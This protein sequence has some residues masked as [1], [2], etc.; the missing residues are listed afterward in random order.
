MAL[1]LW[2]G[3]A[4]GLLEV[5]L[6]AIRKFG[7]GRIL[8]MGL[9]AAWMNPVGNVVFFLVFGAG[10]TLAAR[11]LPRIFTLRTCIALLVFVSCFGLLFMFA[12]QL[13]KY[14]AMVLAAGLAVELSRR[15]SLGSARFD[16][17][18]RRTMRGMVVAVAALALGVRTTRVL[19][20]RR[21]LARL[22]RSE[23][24][25]NVLLIVLDTVRSLN[26]GY[27]GY[28]RPTTPSLDRWSRGGVRF[29]RALSAAP[30]TL[31]SHASMFTGRFPHQLSADWLEPLDPTYPTIAEF[32]RS[33]GYQTAGFVA[34]VGYCSPEFGLNRGFT[35]YED[36]RASPGQMV[37]QMSL[38]AYLTDSRRLRR[39]VGYYDLLGRKKAER[40]TSNFLHW[41]PDDPS[42]PFFAF[43]NYFDAHSPYIP[44]A[45]F[46]TR[47]GSGATRESR[48]L[49]RREDLSDEHVQILRDNYDGSIAY[50][51]HHLDRLFEALRARGLEER[52]LVVVTS[53][54]G[55]E[56]GEHGLLDH[57]NSLYLPAVHVPLVVSFP[58]R[59]PEAEEVNRPVSLRDLA[60]TLT[61]LSHPRSSAP[62]P[63]RPLSRF[64]EDASA[65]SQPQEPL[66]STVR[67][68]QNVPEWIPAGHGDMAAI[69]AGGL[70]YI[71]G[72]DGSEELYDFDSDPGEQRNLIGTPEGKRALPHLRES[73][74]S[75]LRS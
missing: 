62:F 29:R 33:Q 44:P 68:V 52:T 37:R 41:L 72:G 27:H 60:S 67:H 40:L 22:P 12:P 16:P 65:E 66:L 51:D 10:L 70:R 54:H 21:S 55:E 49:S 23:P 74:A 34:N 35:H 1:A 57:G 13:H 24:A 2:F 38:G 71:R 53:D 18:R 48:P 32:Y 25:P 63:G 56:F 31:P 17:I 4:S 45:P 7:F 14:A 28:H 46:S 19:A 26:V 8:W 50:L 20:E 69:V 75:L 58:G 15:L 61:R 47:F 64:W 43:L 30:W 6:L 73:L 59:V 5:V 11:L 42:R 3:L 36:Y 9:D 39:L